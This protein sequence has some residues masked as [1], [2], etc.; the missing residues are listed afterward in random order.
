MTEYIENNG[1]ISRANFGRSDLL[2]VVRSAE[3][4]GAHRFVLRTVTEWLKVY[5]G[6]LEA[7]LL[8][9]KATAA[10]GKIDQA[11]DLLKKILAYDPEYVAAWQLGAELFPAG[12]QERIHAFSC[13]NALG[14]KVGHDHELLPWSE[15]LHLAGRQLKAG[16]YPD[17]EELVYSVLNHY[18]DAIL[19]AICHVRLMA[20]SRDQSGLSSFARVYHVRWPHCLQFSLETARGLLNARDEST[21]MRLFQSSVAADPAGQVARRLWGN[22]HPYQQMWPEKMAIKFDLPVP[23]EVAAQLGWNQLDAPKS[24]TET[25]TQS[26]ICV[27]DESVPGSAEEPELDQVSSHAYQADEPVFRKDTAGATCQRAEARPRRKLPVDPDVAE[28]DHSFQKLAAK[29]HDSKLGNLD[30]RF[31]MYVIFSTRTGL[32]RKFGT[33]IFDI[34]ENEM[35]KLA[36]TVASY[37]QWGG[38]VFLPDDAKCARQFGVE[39]T[40]GIDPWSLKLALADLDQALTKKGAMIGAVLIVG[41]DEVVPF[42]RLPNPTDDLDDDV[43]SDNPYATLDGNYFVPEWPIGRMPDEKGTDPAL[44]LSQLRTAIREHQKKQTGQKTMRAQNLLTQIINFLAALFGR[45]PSLDNLQ[46]NCFGYSA[47]VWRRAS[48]AV[49]R[50][51]GAGQLL[52]VS[53]PQPADHF[54]YGRV[55]GADLGYFNLHGL[56]DSPEWYGQRDIT[57]PYIGPDYP[58]AIRPSD[59]TK[60]G[61]A[62]QVV[63]S[64]ACYGGHVFQKSES[65]SMALRFLSAGSAAVV[66]STCVAYGSVSLPLIGA[67]LLCNL[68]WQ[69]LQEGVSAGEALWRSKIDF[70]QQMEKRQGFLDGEDQKTMISFVLFGDPLARPKGQKMG[71]KSFAR[72]RVPLDV[73]M[74]CDIKENGEQ[75]CKKDVVSEIKQFVEVYLPGLDQAQFS[76]SQEYQ[77]DSD[78]LNHKGI[79]WEGGSAAY[80]KGQAGRTV[81][82]ISK[83]VQGNKKIHHHYARVTL[84]KSGKMVKLALSR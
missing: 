43:A 51:L 6:D 3:T 63:F 67:D 81:V 25:Y 53:P 52:E 9:C 82:T 80:A 55:M 29:Y 71:T 65:E 15:S 19:G 56:A 20:L 10:E 27:T 18:P 46:S 49:F 2:K 11:N 41:G 35:Q 33:Q 58:L 22:D 62:P 4:A 79:G 34:L 76:F 50:P 30:G 59:L 28:I 8:Q 48:I 12:S 14:Q 57:E 61:K 60:N 1:R 7:N 47:A 44:L 54:D 42:H 23:A 64:E 77:I 16:E 68:F 17:A 40:K 66:A 37:P 70:I 36:A 38:L 73:R 39:V 32:E 45:K 13:L 74:V 31:P 26:V 21:A 72:M 69:H 24:A 78:Y 75:V 5:P 83:Q 84:D